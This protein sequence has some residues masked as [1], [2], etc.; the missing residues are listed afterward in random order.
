MIKIKI[1]PSYPNSNDF[2]LN[3]AQLWV[4]FFKAI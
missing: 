2:H 1:I 4:D 3:L